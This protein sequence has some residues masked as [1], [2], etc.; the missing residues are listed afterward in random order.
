MTDYLSVLCKDILYYIF[1]FLEDIRY[2]CNLRLVSKRINRLCGEWKISKSYRVIKYAQVALIHFIIKRDLGSIRFI[3]SKGISPN[4]KHMREYPISISTNL[5]YTEITRELV[6]MGAEPNVLDHISNAPVEIT[7][8][9][10]D[11]ETTHFLVANGARVN[12]DRKCILS[13]ALFKGEKDMISLLIKNGA[14]WTKDSIQI[15]IINK[16]KSYL[17]EAIENG[18]EINQEF[19]EMAL[20]LKSEESLK[21]VLE[22]VPSSLEILKDLFSGTHREMQN[23]FSEEFLQRLE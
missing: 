1:D 13:K 14:K 6:I 10:S 12:L 23:H 4:F 16:D 9:R 11:Y 22:K 20:M 3:L 7:V 5:G 8:S 21:L 15:A 2:L 19:L 17:A 18:L